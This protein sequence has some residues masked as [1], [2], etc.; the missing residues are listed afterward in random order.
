VCFDIIKMFLFSVKIFV[1]KRQFK[2][3]SHCVFRHCKNVFIFCEMLLR[4]ET[5]QD[6]GSLCVSTL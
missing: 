3:M 4:K 1:G 5:I 2:I 6:E